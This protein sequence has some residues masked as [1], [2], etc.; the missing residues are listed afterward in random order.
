MFL[1]TLYGVTYNAYSIGHLQCSVCTFA[2]VSAHKMRWH[3]S[4]MELKLH[5]YIVS[6]QVM[7]SP[8]HSYA[9]KKMV[10]VE[11]HNYCFSTITNTYTVHAMYILYRMISS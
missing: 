5:P 4:E 10:V 11:R 7:V 6:D 8:L 3:I 2:Q 1:C 9:I